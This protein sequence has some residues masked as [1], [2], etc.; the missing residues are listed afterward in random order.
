MLLKAKENG[1][2]RVENEPKQ[3]NSCVSNRIDAK[4]AALDG[5]IR[6][7]LNAYSIGILSQEIQTNFAHQ[8]L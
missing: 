4:L 6:T 1:R 3:L 5:M 2:F 8:S 7:P